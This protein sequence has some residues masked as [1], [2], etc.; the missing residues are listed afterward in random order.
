MQNKLE[1]KVCTEPT[2][3]GLNGECSAEP[4]YAQKVA[5]EDET[6]VHREVVDQLLRKVARELLHRGLMHD[7]SKLE[8]PELSGFAKYLPLMKSVAFGSPEYE[9]FRAKLGPSLA[10]HYKVNSHHPEHDRANGVM[11][12]T[13]IDLTEMLCDWSASSKRNANGSIEKS[14]Q[15][16]KDRFKISDELAQILWNTVL[17]LKLEG[18]GEKSGV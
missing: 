13:L 9:L 3:L 16:C 10:Q 4:T 8:E 5:C 11:G 14:L 15:I 17:S 6:R 18:G 12:M 7:A 1:C 2:C